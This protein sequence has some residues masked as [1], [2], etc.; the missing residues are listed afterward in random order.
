MGT[1]VGEAMLL[2]AAMGGGSAAITGGDPLKGALLGVLTGGAGAGISGALGGAAG[3][4][5]A[6]LG[7]ATAPTATTLAGTAPGLT[8]SSTLGSGLGNSLA[9]LDTG[10]GTGANYALNAAP[11]GL[12]A[13]SSLSGLNPSVA[14]SAM[15][16]GTNF[17]LNAPSM[18]PGA[19]S[20]FALGAPSMAPGG[21]GIANLS[22]AAPVTPA[23]TT[24]TNLFADPMKYMGEHKF[25]AG[26]SALAGAI[27]ARPDPFEPEEYNGPLKRFRL[28]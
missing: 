23:A 10:I 17:A 11:Q 6:A 19:A 20:N 28:S 12:N 2:G 15:Q 8:A 21:G 22:T 14:Q 13:A 24:P 25:L 9:A 26:S 5:A 27:G 1:G 18:A 7:S 4:E 16:G 3:A